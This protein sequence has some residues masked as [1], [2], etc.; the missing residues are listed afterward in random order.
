MI[1]MAIGWVTL[2]MA[3]YLIK[4]VT[5]M[6][7]TVMTKLI[8]LASNRLS[9]LLDSSAATQSY[10]RHPYMVLVKE[11][12]RNLKK[13]CLPIQ[14][15]LLALFIIVFGMNILGYTNYDSVKYI[16]DIFVILSVI[17][18]IIVLRAKDYKDTKQL[19]DASKR[20]VIIFATV[21]GVLLS[22]L[23]MIHLI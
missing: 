18:L 7:L 22:A 4:M 20:N 6:D 13:I 23:V 14:L 5:G 17:N 12:N 2:K 1:T 16:L 15:F 9:W 19:P 8:F 3:V 11:G 21:A 10:P